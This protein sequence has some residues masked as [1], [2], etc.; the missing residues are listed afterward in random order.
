MQAGKW[1]QIGNPFVELEDGQEVTIN[2]VFSDGF[3]DGDSLYIYDSSKNGYVATFLWTTVNDVAGWYDLSTDSLATFKVAVGQ[4]VFINKA[5]DGNVTV[6][7]RVSEVATVS[8][9]GNAWSQVVC[10]YPVA[11]TMNEMTWIGMEDGDSA[12]IYDSSVGGYTSS[13]LYIKNR[14][15]MTTGWYD[16]STD[17]FATTKLPIGQSIFINKT[18]S[19]EGKLSSSL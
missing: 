2:D 12:Y 7:G 19:G 8:I 14:P 16:L 6:K 3:G 10:V 18:S 13:Y 9:L 5:T 17:S 4:G 15:G 1:Y 11:K